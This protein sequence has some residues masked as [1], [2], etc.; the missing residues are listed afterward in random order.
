MS[1]PGL[2]EAL[3]DLVLLVKRDGTV[4]EHAGGRAVAELGGCDAADRE[5][6]VP[7]W[8]ESTAALIRQLTRNAIADRTAVEARFQ[9]RDTRYEVRVTA[10]GPDRA[11]CVIR[12]VLGSDGGD[13]GVAPVAAE[14]RPNDAHRPVR[15]LRRDADFIA[16]VALLETG[17]DRRAVGNGVACELADERGRRL[18][19]RGHESL[20]VRRVA[21]A[22]LGDGPS[23]CVLDHGTVP[24]H[25]QNQIG[26]RF[27][28]TRR[29]HGP[30]CTEK[31]PRET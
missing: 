15:A 3:P 26:Q 4:V 13:A 30:H 1:T 23:A 31:A 19:P 20:T 11:M 8:S 21:A 22:E 28:E 6:F 12:P 5:R 16:R 2:I 9:E 24:L 25:E 27:D 10:Q 14:H 18:R 7:A 17:L 29:R